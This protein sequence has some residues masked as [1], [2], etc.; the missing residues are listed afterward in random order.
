MDSFL[1]GM[2]FNAMQ[3][4][5]AI[6]AGQIQ[7]IRP[8]GDRVHIITRDIRGTFELVL[9]LNGPAVAEPNGDSIVSRRAWNEGRDIVITETLLDG[10]RNSKPYAVCRR[11]LDP[12]GRMNVDVSKRT[13]SGD[14]VSMRIVYTRIDATPERVVPQRRA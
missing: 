2:G 1:K 4:A 10:N 11:S 3:R 8:Q 5:T 13:R 14:L 7:V 12:R 9:P 6:K